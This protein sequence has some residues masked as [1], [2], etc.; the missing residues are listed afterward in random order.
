[1]IW[2]CFVLRDKTDFLLMSVAVYYGFGRHK[3]DIPR[4][5]GNIVMAFKVRTALPGSSCMLNSG[6]FFYIFQV[7][8]KVVLCMN[9]LSFLT[10]YLRM[11]PTRRFRMI[12]YITI[13]VIVTGVCAYV[14]ATI[15]QC[16]PVSAFWYRSIPKR[17]IKNSWFRWWWAGYNTA[18][19]LWVFMMPMPVLARLKL[20][21]ARK[22][23]VMLIFA[24]GLFVCITSIIRMQAMVKSVSTTD[25]TWGPF[26]ALLWSAIE[27]D[28]GIICACLPFLKYPL[29]RMFPKL[30]FSSGSSNPSNS[31]NRKGPASKPGDS[32]NHEN[33]CEQNTVDC[34]G[35]VDQSE[36]GIG[37]DPVAPGQ[38]VMKTDISLQTDY[39]TQQEM[40][41][42]EKLIL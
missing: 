33:H 4:T 18:T 19:N 31:G 22:I 3:V 29:R 1:M 24:L 30:F 10:F 9:K 16:I 7:L 42:R 13:A 20:N 26:D 12:C 11:F 28:C 25:P 23:G 6:Q 21:L 40:R 38:I 27:A 32:Q 37:Y 2:V 41:E 36:K 15:F 8:Y 34:V 14:F 17:C 35:A 5:G 39:I